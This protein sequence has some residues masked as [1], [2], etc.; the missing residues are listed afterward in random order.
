M[1]LSTEANDV[2]VS[3]AFSATKNPPRIP[4]NT[5]PVF[6]G[7]WSCI[8]HHLLHLVTKAMSDRLLAEPPVHS[9]QPR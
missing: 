8:C 1:D 3:A 7:L 5:L 2:S 6:R 9:G 4:T